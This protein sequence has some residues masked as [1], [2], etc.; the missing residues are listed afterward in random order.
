MREEY[1]PAG[2]GD[3]GMSIIDME[4][5]ALVLS[6]DDNGEVVLMVRCDEQYAIDTLR[7]VA[8]DIEENGFQ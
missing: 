2:P 1:P 6:V 3:R 7:A 4:N 8:D 5:T